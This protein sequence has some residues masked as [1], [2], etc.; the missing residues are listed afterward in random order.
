MEVERLGI[1]TYHQ[2]IILYCNNAGCIANQ[3]LIHCNTDLFL[4][5]F[6]ITKSQVKLEI[7]PPIPL[8]NV[9]KIHFTDNDPKPQRLKGLMLYDTGVAH[10]NSFVSYD[11]ETGFFDTNHYNFYIDD[12]INLNHAQ[13]CFLFFF[14][15]VLTLI[16]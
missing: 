6:L 4:K 13:V 11:S 3:V 12:G 15:F 10:N 9:R 14:F 7:L 5:Q 8:F 1:T 16:L 2:C